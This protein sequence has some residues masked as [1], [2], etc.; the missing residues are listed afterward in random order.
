MVNKIKNR[1]RLIWSDIRQF[2][3]LELYLILVVILALFIVD[4]FGEPSPSALTEI[5]LAAIAV[6]IY[7]QIEARHLERKTTTHLEA[8][9]QKIDRLQ[10]GK[11][12]GIKVYAEGRVPDF[13][14]TSF[15]FTAQKEIFVIG[16]STT[17]LRQ[18][19]T[20][21]SSSYFKEPIFDKIGKGLQV[22]WYLLDSE[23][24]AAKE[25]AAD[26]Q[27]PEIPERIEATKKALAKIVQ[28]LRQRNGDGVFNVYLYPRFPYCYLIM[29]DPEDSHGQMIVSHYLHNLSRKDTPIYQIE[30]SHHPI[31]FDRYAQ[32]VTD[33]TAESKLIATSK[34]DR[35][36]A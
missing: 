28:E 19:F 8:L 9:S 23:S 29:I 4:I 21:Q 35:D 22:H 2:K 11:E 33:L 15:F 10:E 7:G 36:Q 12:T 18:R 34:P 27:E 26:R 6:L 13:D 24:T 32:M 30:K 31:L 16:I 5:L 25:Y 3:N 1:L 17:N 20:E 14:F